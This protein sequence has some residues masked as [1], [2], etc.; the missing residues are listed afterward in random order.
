M[1]GALAVK[2]VD[3]PGV[4]AKAT[5]R[6][7]S[8]LGAWISVAP[9]PRGANGAMTSA[10]FAGRWAVSMTWVASTEPLNTLVKPLKA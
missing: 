7:P 9:L 6:P 4:R 2:I 1:R 10:P 5:G 8:S 3:M